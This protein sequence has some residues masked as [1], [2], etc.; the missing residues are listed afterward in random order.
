M[1]ELVSD[2]FYHI[3]PHKYFT[4][5]VLLFADSI[6]LEWKL[7]CFYFYSNR[8]LLITY[9]INSKHIPR[10]LRYLAWPLLCKQWDGG[11]F[12]P[13]PTPH[14]ITSHPNFS[15]CGVVNP[16]TNKIIYFYKGIS[17]KKKKL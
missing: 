10:Y 5:F 1:S 6:A 15:F 2:L 3:S 13:F 11:E 12:P 4:Y 7:A 14:H 8:Y 16:S 17:A 9:S